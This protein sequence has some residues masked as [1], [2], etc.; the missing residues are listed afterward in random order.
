MNQK[1]G[2]RLTIAVLL[3]WIFLQ[4]YTSF[5]IAVH[6][7]CTVC[8]SGRTVALAVLWLLCLLVLD[9]LLYF[10]GRRRLLWE[11]KWY[12]GACA[13]LVAA[14]LVL[15][16]LLSGLMLFVALIFGITPWLQM[17]LASHLLLETAL[18]LSSKTADMGGIALTLLLIGSQ[19]LWMARLERRLQ[20]GRQ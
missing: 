6:S 15:S 9:T 2:N 18:G 13:M 7:F 12:W 20:P 17:L 10:F 5:D 3:V 8:Y 19:F 11:L 1:N 14:L 4:L 16:G